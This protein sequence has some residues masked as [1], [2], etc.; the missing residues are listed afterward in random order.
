MHDV[1]MDLFDGEPYA[2][3]MPRRPRRLIGWT[4]F[5][6]IAFIPAARNWVVDQAQQ[7]VVHEIRPLLGHLDEGPTSSTPARRDHGRSSAP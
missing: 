6:A 1:P 3:L 5:L 4:L 7:H 2:D